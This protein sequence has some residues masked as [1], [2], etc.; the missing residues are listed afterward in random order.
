[1]KKSMVQ[2]GLIL[3]VF[4]TSCGQTPDSSLLNSTQDTSA[5]AVSAESLATELI[6]EMP[7]I[8]TPS[9]QSGL[10][11]SI[12]TAKLKITHEL[13][14]NIYKL[15]LS[16]LKTGEKRKEN[17]EII[18][19]SSGASYGFSG[20][21]VVLRDNKTIKVTNVVTSSKPFERE[22]I[23]DHKYD[24][25][26]DSSSPVVKVNLEVFKRTMIPK[27]EVLPLLRYG[28]IGPYG[29]EPFKAIDFDCK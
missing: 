13:G 9:N 2:T 27:E 14:V 4:I 7:K 24:F 6:C 25:K 11:D 10:A 8:V 29:K 17:G 1:M 21:G 19:T 5:Q 28:A 15:H 12:Q 16:T 3:S 23:Y 22:V 18:K 20:P 26:I